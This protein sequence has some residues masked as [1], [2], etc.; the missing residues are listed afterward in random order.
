MINPKD[1]VKTQI[2]A[3]TVTMF[4]VGGIDESTR[5]ETQTRNEIGVRS[6]YNA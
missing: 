3:Q 1:N 4:I 2:N 5:F 6:K